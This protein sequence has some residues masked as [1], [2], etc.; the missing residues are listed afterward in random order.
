MAH[1]IINGISAKSGGGKSILV[2]FL[3]TLH[4]S[5][6]H[7]TFSVFVSDSADLREMASRNMKII[8][9]SFFSKQMMLPLTTRVILPHLIKKLK[10]DIILNFSD[11]PIPS[12]TPQIFLFDWPYAAYPESPAWRRGGLS[13]YFKRVI[14][15]HFFRKHL[16]YVDVL[17]AQGPAL[18]ERLQKLYCWDQVPIVPNAVSLENLRG[19]NTRDFGLRGSFKLLC[20]SR[21]YAHKNLEIFIDLAERIKLGALDWKIVVTID[22]SQG[23]GAKRFLR[24]IN[25][26]NLTEIIQNVGPVCM[27]DV[28]SLY[29]Q[30]DALLL[31]SLLESFS[32]TYVEAMFHGKPVFTSN[33]DFA[34]DVCGDAAFYFD[35]LNGNDIFETVYSA[36]EDDDL[37]QTKIMNGVNRLSEM[38]TWDQ[39]Y[40][41]YMNIIEECLKDNNA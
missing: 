21:Y 19:R 17:I 7:H 20:L 39:A 31:P 34:T 11:L 5:G 41:G 30:C 18:R 37:R 28:P 13:V 16:S 36:V 12:V 1:I 29:Q 22:K 38:Y 9:F 40:E 2:N 33:Y 32:G 24:E 35:P 15:Y 27:D 8:S 23:V 6:T 10:G 4:K 14:K 3:R 25:R 26:R